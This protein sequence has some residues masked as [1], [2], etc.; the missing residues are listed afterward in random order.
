MSQTQAADSTQKIN[1]E[2]ANYDLGC[3]KARIKFCDLTF[4]D[5]FSGVLDAVVLEVRKTI[6]GVKS[7]GEK[8]LIR[9]RTVVHC[10]GYSRIGLGGNR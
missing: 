7:E 6:H 9:L 8:W 2:L 5:H 10:H 1:Q 3:L 4:S